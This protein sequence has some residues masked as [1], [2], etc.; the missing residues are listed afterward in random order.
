MPHQVVV[1]SCL[2][3]LEYL[4]LRRQFIKSLVQGLEEGE[5]LRGLSN[6]APSCKSRN[7]GE[8]DCCIREP[9]G[10]W[11]GLSELVSR[12][13]LDGKECNVPYL[14]IRNGFTFE[15]ENFGWRRFGFSCF[16][17]GIR[18]VKEMSE[19]VFRSDSARGTGLLLL[20]LLRL[21]ETSANV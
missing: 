12:W 7:V 2:L 13:N 16:N 14:Q 17:G 18:A 6:A 20:V 15:A 19:S 9:S 10:S 11:Q 5:N 3:Y 21:V 4:P 8:E 1:S